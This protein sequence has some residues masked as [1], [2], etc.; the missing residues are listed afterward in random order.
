MNKTI[1]NLTV[2]ASLGFSAQGFAHEGG[3]VNDAYVGDSKGHIVTDGSGDCV[4]TSS[5]SEDKMIEGCGLVAVVAEPAPA[6]PVKVVTETV[7]LS[8]ETLFDVDKDVIKPAGKV[9]LDDFAA[10]LSTLNTV[11]SV[12]IV[13]HTDST[14]TDA[15]NQA[16]SMRRANS[17]KNYLLDKGVSSSVMSTSGMGESQPVASNATSEGRTQNRRVEVSFTGTETEVVK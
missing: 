9:K 1:L 6:P 10:R 15:Y 11:E 8:A 2:A 5:W 17:V 3:M 14:G 12:S 7:S 13:G 16:L 4:R